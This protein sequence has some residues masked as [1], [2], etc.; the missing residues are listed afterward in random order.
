[1]GNSGW[2]SFAPS[3]SAGSCFQCVLGSCQLQNQSSVMSPSWFQELPPDPPACT[4]S[5]LC[6]SSRTLW[7]QGPAPEGSSSFAAPGPCGS[8]SCAASGPAH[9]WCQLVCESGWLQ[10]QLMGNSGWSSFAPS[11]PAGSCF[12]CVLGSC[13][14]Q[15]QSSVMSPCWFQELPPDPP[16][17]T[18]SL[19]CCSSRTLWPQG[20]APEGSSSFAAPGPCGSS[21]CAAS[22]PAHGWCQLVCESVWLQLQLM[23]SSGWSSFAP[24]GPAGSCFQCVLDPS[25]FQNQSRV[26]SSS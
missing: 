22:G 5:L 20:P 19:L 10:L 1:M 12:Q 9:G 16:A 17:C 7:P 2:S 4:P 15:N 24:S 13:Q 3:G 18:P 21:S 6:C 23:G 25:W 14:L 8:S 26:I 11:G